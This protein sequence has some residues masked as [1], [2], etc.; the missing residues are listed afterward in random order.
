MSEGVILLDA[1]ATCSFSNSAAEAIFGK[2]LRRISIADWATEFGPRHADSA[3][4]AIE[5][6]PF[7]QALH[8]TRRQGRS[9][10]H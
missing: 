5:E 2:T 9:L 10:V 7:V 8:G 4:Y 1:Q 6:L 3:P